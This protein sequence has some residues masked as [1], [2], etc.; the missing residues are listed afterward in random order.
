MSDI[1]NSDGDDNDAS[2][3]PVKT[4]ANFEMIITEY[5]ELASCLSQ[6]THN[7]D[8]GRVSF[9]AKGQRINSNLV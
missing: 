4:L 9:G 7:N 3:S 5:T 6:S 1:D 2:P 8:V